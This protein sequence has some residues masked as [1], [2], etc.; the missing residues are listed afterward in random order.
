MFCTT[1]HVVGPLGFPNT[2]AMNVMLTTKRTSLLQFRTSPGD[3][4]T[5][6]KRIQE[7][8]MYK[9]LALVWTDLETDRRPYQHLLMQLSVFSSMKIH[10]VDWNLLVRSLSL[11]EPRIG[12]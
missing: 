4:S 7:V 9:I 12:E 2:V 5:G 10:F 6:E 8:S 11:C 3:G 1:R